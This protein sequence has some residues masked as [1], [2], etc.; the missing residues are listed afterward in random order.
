MRQ[1]LIIL[2]FPVLT[3][4]TGCVIRQPPVSLSPLGPSAAPASTGSPLAGSVDEGLPGGPT[5]PTAPTSPGS[6]VVDVGLPDA[7]TSP[8]NAAYLPVDVRAQQGTFQEVHFDVVIHG[9]DNPRAFSVSHDS[10]LK[11]LE[12]SSRFIDAPAGSLRLAIDA[13]LSEPATAGH[14]C[15]IALLRA[16]GGALRLEAVAPADPARARGPGI[17]GTSGNVFISPRWTSP[18][19]IR[20][21]F[22]GPF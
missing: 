3:L 9:A 1:T 13:T 16:E 10:N 4:G 20:S 5:E 19:I 8:G 12:F 21:A 18:V 14:L 22:A 11:I 17:V 15:Q 2:V 7:G 6:T